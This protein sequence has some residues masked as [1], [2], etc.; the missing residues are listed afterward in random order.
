MTGVIFATAREAGPYLKMMRSKPLK[1]RRPAIFQHRNQPALVTLIS[2]MGPAAAEVAAR[3][4]IDDWGVER[5]VNAGICGALRSGGP[6]RP[7]GVF[8]VRHARTASHKTCK[9]SRAITC[10]PGVWDKL[11]KADLVT[12]SRPLFDVVLRRKL[13]R[14]GALVDMEGAAIAKLAH[15]RRLPCTLIK[16]ITDRAT[17]GARADLHR[18][19]VEVSGRIAKILAVGLMPAAADNHRTV[20]TERKHHDDEHL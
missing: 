17:E 1:H 18:R 6:W 10:T 5:L 7:R 16:G 2:G 19:L 4:A 14:W 3:T 13:A 12:L 15:D 11:P 20:P 9:P 8:A